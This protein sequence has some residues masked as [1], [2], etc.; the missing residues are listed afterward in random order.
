LDN[1]DHCLVVPLMIR[2]IIVARREVV[3]VIVVVLARS[4]LAFASDLTGCRRKRIFFLYAQIAFHSV[5]A[6][7]VEG[8]AIVPVEIVIPSGVAQ[9]SQKFVAEVFGKSHRGRVAHDDKLQVQV[10]A[11]GRVVMGDTHFRVDEILEPV[12]VV[13]GRDGH[14]EAVGDGCNVLGEKMATDIVDLKA[15]APTKL[16]V[17]QARLG[18]RSRDWWRCRGRISS[19]L[20][21]A[22]TAAGQHVVEMCHGDFGVGIVEGILDVLEFRERVSALTKVVS[23]NWEGY[24]SESKGSSKEKEVKL[25]G[26]K[27]ED[28]A[29]RFDFCVIDGRF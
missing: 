13:G 23:S 26:W 14:L 4:A 20:A 24:L 1:I 9:S 16:V 27:I 15:N 10:H 8:I 5:R 6:G 12:V 21:T 11:A 7:N 25:H 2:S 17:G 29:R 3:I 19:T 22:V 28:R 18:C